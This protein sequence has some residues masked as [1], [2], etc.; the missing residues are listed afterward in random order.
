VTTLLGRMTGYDPFAAAEPDE[1]GTPATAAD[2]ILPGLPRGSRARRRA[3]RAARALAPYGAAVGAVA[4]VSAATGAP[5]WFTLMAAGGS[6]AHA[7]ELA[8]ERWAHG[9]RGGRLFERR[10]RRYQGEAGLGDIRSS[11]S[12]KHAVAEMA[13]LAPGLPA[14]Q[15]HIA[16]GTSLR[17]PARTVAIDRAQS[18][19]CVAPP[20]TI[21][22]VWMSGALLDAPGAALATSSRADQFRQT[23]AVRSQLGPVLVLDA[24]NRGPGTNFAWSP[25][26]GCESPLTAMRRAGEFMHASPRDPS[27]KD[28]WHEDR[29]RRLVQL[30]FH[31]A[32][33]SGRDM[34]AV[35]AWCQQPDDE[36]FAKA[37][38]HPRTAPG[39][40]DTLEALLGQE[41]E[42]LNSATTSAEAALGWMDDPELAAV[43]CPEDGGLDVAGF[44]RQ[45]CGTIYLIGR[46][47]AHGSLTPFFTTFVS[48]YMEQAYA[49]AEAQGG[50]LRVPMTLVLDEAATTARVDLAQHLS[51]TAG[52]N[53]T[54]LVGLQAISQL[55]ANWGGPAQAEIILN[56]LTTKVIG[57]GFT[58]VADLDRLSRVCG[59]HR[60]WRKEAG[61][62]VY[63]SEPVFPPERIRLLPQ[64]HVLVVHRNAKS[65]EVKASVVYEHPLYRPVVIDPAGSPEEE[66]GNAVW[67]DRAGA[68]A[69]E[70][71][72][73]PG[74]RDAPVP[75]APAPGQ[76]AAGAR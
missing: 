29:G 64:G 9:A 37:L 47:R 35:R 15:A 2:R 8:A 72:Q 22:T 36:D 57:G 30:A 55:E 56:N 45:G 41:P 61:Q 58:S 38:R 3:A 17:R 68:E 10:R 19:L 6:L 42:F 76:F 14:A 44:L 60:V 63:S 59:D 62:K 73:A 69:P 40:A 21:K 54:V 46:H 5:D 23:Y 67:P 18:V 39:W 75:A 48:E 13:R 51:V 12:V 1:S 50:R 32:A 27:G 74:P 34:R 28:S 52:Y 53:I 7:G 20:Q 70:A 11:L 26:R 33:L 24:D 71:R 16:I 65:L 25:V 66:A 31:A 43:A 49:L 4:V